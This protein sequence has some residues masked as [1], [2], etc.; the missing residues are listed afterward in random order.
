MASAFLVSEQE[1]TL[2]TCRV[3]KWVLPSSTTKYFA[4]P[5]ILTGKPR[6]GETSRNYMS[7]AHVPIYD[8]VSFSQ[9]S[10][11]NVTFK[12][13]FRFHLK[14][15][16]LSK[17]SLLSS[18]V[19][20][21]KRIYNLV[22]ETLSYNSSIDLFDLVEKKTLPFSYSRVWIG[23]NRLVECVF[24]FMRRTRD[25]ENGSNTGSS[26]QKFFL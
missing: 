17:M 4:F 24:D 18:V 13:F 25:V 3:A 19:S 11:K 12:I 2:E 8:V 6:F 15:K 16:R 23:H 10:F 1:I 22:G 21:A 5:E 26:R 9:I 14:N 20:L 7:C